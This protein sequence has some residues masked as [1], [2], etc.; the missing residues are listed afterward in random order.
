MLNGSPN[1]IHINAL[2]FSECHSEGVI[3]FFGR[4][5]YIKKFII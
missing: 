1:M 5:V 3:H 2:D 4:L